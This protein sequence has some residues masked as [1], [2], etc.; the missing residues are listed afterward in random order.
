MFDTY[1]RMACMHED[2]VTQAAVGLPLSV[3]HGPVLLAE[4]CPLMAAHSPFKLG[5][6]RK[7]RW[8][9]CGSTGR[10][11]ELLPDVVCSDAGQASTLT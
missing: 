11:L 8:Q 4:P 9:L 3:L 2:H 1:L 5:S 10:Q 6:W 7:C